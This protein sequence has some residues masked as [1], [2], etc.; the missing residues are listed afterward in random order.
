MAHRIARAVGGLVDLDLVFRTAV[1]AL[2]AHLGDDGVAILRCDHRAGRFVLA[3]SGGGLRIAGDYAQDLDSGLLGAAVRTG[4]P[5]VT[6]DADAD[7]RCVRAPAWR[8]CAR[9]W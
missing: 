6:D 9:S 1:D 4:H 5:V 3:A 2:Q 7:P 8:A